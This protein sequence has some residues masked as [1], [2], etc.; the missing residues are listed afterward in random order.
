M[1]GEPCALCVL[2]PC[3]SHIVVSKHIK[4]FKAEVI[5][6]DAISEKVVKRVIS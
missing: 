2:S 3:P 6:I 5:D 1:A 4:K